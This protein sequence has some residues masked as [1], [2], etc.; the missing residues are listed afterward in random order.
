MRQVDEMEGDHDP[1]QSGFD[2]EPLLLGATDPLPHWPGTTAACVSASWSALRSIRVLPFPTTLPTL[3]PC[4]RGPAGAADVYRA[5]WRAQAA[6]AQSSYWYY[7]AESKTYYPYVKE[8][9]GG[10]QR[11]TPQQRPAVEPAM[12]SREFSTGG[13]THCWSVREP[14]SGPSVLVLQGSAKLRSVPLRRRRLPRIANVQIG[15]TSPSDAAASSVAKS[16][17]VGTE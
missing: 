10:W 12:N 9:P 6:P 8:C 2:L 1:D 16:A 13:N 7:C 4:R 3:S 5:G 15:G 11:V 14:A 17:A